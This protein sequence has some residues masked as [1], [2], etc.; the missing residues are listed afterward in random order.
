MEVLGKRSRRHLILS[1][2]SVKDGQLTYR[3]KMAS[4]LAFPPTLATSNM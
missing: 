1:V 3:Y 2:L 4:L